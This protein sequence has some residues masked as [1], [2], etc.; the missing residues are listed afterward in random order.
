M[1]RKTKSRG[2]ASRARRTGSQRPGRWPLQ[3]A[4]GR[5]SE[6]VRKVKSDGPQ[7]VTVHGRDEVIV[8]SVQEFGRLTGGLKGEALVRLMQESPL[9]DVDIEPPRMRLPVR[10]VSL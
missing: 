5:F 2:T 10:D 8:V 6:L 7:V 3:D 9:R 1:T 4:K